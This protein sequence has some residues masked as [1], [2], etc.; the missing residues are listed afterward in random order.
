[1]TFHLD[2]NLTNK[3]LYPRIII[4]HTPKTWV[5]HLILELCYI[6]T[7]LILL[8][9]SYIGP[10]PGPTHPQVG[11]TY[12]ISSKN[13]FI[14]SCNPE[15]LLKHSLK[16]FVTVLTKYNKLEVYC[17]SIRF[18]NRSFRSIIDPKTCP[19]ETRWPY[20]MKSKTFSRL[21]PTIESPSLSPNTEKQKHLSYSVSH[22]Y[23]QIKWR[24]S[25]FVIK[26]GP[27]RLISYKTQVFNI[28]CLPGST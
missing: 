19:N 23:T 22:T 1:M 4:K 2:L 6:G 9:R 7:L 17:T 8:P 14:R 28:L 5:F 26:S 13:R 15:S 16:R 27:S 10:Y 25:N 18:H 20:Q 11:A 3:V 24:F 21:I 12:G